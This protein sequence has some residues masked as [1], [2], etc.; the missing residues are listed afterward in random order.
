MSRIKKWSKNYGAYCARSRRLRKLKPMMRAQLAVEYKALEQL[1]NAVKLIM[2]ESGLPT[3]H[4]IAYLNFGRQVYRLK[5]RFS[6]NMLKREIDLLIMMARQKLLKK[7]ILVKI[8]D[9]VLGLP[10]VNSHRDTEL[11]E[12][13]RNKKCPLN[14]KP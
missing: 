2:G 11:T 3:W 12:K 8:R 7:S 6:G 14:S 13:K 10:S 4:N 5:K 9:T 1:E